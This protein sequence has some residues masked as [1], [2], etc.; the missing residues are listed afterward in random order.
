MCINTEDNYRIYHDESKIDGYW[1]GMLLV[2]ENTR[3]H[4]LNLL[5]EGRNANDY[6]AP[7]A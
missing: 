2:P 3:S 6:N 7:L 4:L 1:H 5:K